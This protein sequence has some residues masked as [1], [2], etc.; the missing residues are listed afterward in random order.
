MTQ[1]AVAL[2]EIEPGI[3]Q[4]IMQDRV[5][6]NTF[7]KVLILGLKR[8]FASIQANSS[9]K[10]VILTGYGSYFAPLVVRKR[11]CWPFRKVRQIF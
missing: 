6:K 9:Y 10:V 3:V 8:S 4:L 7:S 5:H 11:V 1:S 2:N